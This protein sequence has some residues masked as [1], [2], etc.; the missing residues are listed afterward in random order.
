M[1]AGKNESHPMANSCGRAGSHIFR[2]VWLSTLRGACVAEQRCRARVAEQRGAAMLV[3]E[4][5]GYLV[6]FGIPS[7][8]TTVIHGTMA[9]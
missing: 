7:P 4:V 8:N 9:T 3:A 5:G 1:A 2:D 6:Y